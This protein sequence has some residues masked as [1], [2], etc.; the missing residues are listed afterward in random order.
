MISLPSKDMVEKHP[1]AS[2]E[3][4]IRALL[5]RYR[6][7]YP[8]PQLRREH[9]I[10]LNGPWAFAVDQNSACAD[11][12]SVPWSATINVPF[13]PETAASGVRADGYLPC[14]WYRRNFRKPDLAPG[15]CLLLHFG[16]VDY[17]ADVWVNGI[18]VCSHH[19]GYTPFQA[20]ITG[21]L[22]NSDLQ[23]IVVRAQDDPL[24]LAKPRGKQDWKA[25]PHSI[26]YVRT[27]G[28]WQTVWLE[29]VPA[30]FIE[31]LKWT[32]NLKRWEIGLDARIGGP[33]RDGL[34]LH[35]SL[36]IGDLVL[37]SDSYSVVA[38]EV[39]RQVAFSDPGIDDSRN[40][41][42]WNPSSPT[43]IHAKLELRDTAGKLIDTVRSY[44]ALRT[45]GVEGDRFILNGR[46]L[47]LR[48][49]LDQGYWP[50]T[51]LTAPND[52]ALLKDVLLAKRLG[53][54]GVRKHQKIEDPRYLYWADRVGLLVW[55]EMP[56]AYRYTTKSI[57]RLTREWIE[58]LNRDSSH[59]CIVAW[60]PLNESWGVPNLPQSFAQR[61][62]VQALY[63]LTKCLDPTRP[64][65]GNDGWESV[66]TDIL[67]IHDYDAEPERIRK[68]YGQEDVESRLLKRERPGGRLLV[69]N[70]DKQIDIS[71]HPLVLSE[72]GGIAYS[73]DG[74]TWGYSRSHT[75]QEFL[76]RFR[77]LL[78]VVRS[79]PN[80][81]GFCYTQFADT[82]QE[83]N[84]IL[85]SNREPK[86]PFEDIAR[87]VKG[88]APARNDVEDLRWR[89]L[90]MQGQRLA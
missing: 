68:R 10:S 6:C 30:S 26:W 52:E 75:P 76:E 43:I 27:T 56:S 39:H 35:V 87:A 42:L 62:Y 5:A 38:S 45:I 47:R 70:G 12:A 44:T 24:D 20:D 53:F 11:P 41:L 7:D 79:L 67:G 81:A 80:L 59:P 28:I 48:L 82:Y 3:P 61:N 46:P 54:N 33:Q 73:S 57:E 32:S 84:G 19:G 71:D 90:V 22:N 72:F 25:N 40:E 69:V 1:S 34:Q 2:D 83:A 13:S 23:E 74:Q 88:D 21:A 14:V 16:A 17:C 29:V 64:V 65:I 58:V 31:T 86:A 85:F 49:V 55:E 66:A 9:W 8:R 36:H 63:H 4:L 51:G 18:K 15:E 50:E 78:E 89:E 77:A 37:A 60:V